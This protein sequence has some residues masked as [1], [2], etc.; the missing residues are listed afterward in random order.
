MLFIQNIF[1]V[2]VT[3]LH[4]LGKSCH[5]CKWPNEFRTSSTPC[6]SQRV[7]NAGV[8]DCPL[9]VLVCKSH[10]HVPSLSVPIVCQNV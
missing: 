6:T 8:K 3:E 4:V 10:R 1:S 2:A 9:V 7:I 5:S